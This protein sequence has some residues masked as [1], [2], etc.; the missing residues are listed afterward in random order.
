[1]DRVLFEHEAI[2]SSHG[3]RTIA[4]VLSR[5]PG[6]EVHVFS[7]EHTDAERSR[8]AREL[9]DKLVAVPPARLHLKPVTYV[10]PTRGWL[11]GVAGRIDG[12]TMVVSSLPLRGRSNLVLT[13]AEG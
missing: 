8:I 10:G 1:M 2:M 6:A 11:E 3:V 12:L 5:H 9:H 4:W 7:S 13:R